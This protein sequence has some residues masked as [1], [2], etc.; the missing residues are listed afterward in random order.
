M[1]A[2]AGPRVRWWP[3]LAWPVD[4]PVPGAPR[5]PRGA[6]GP[7]RGPAA[8]GPLRGGVPLLTGPPL[9]SDGQLMV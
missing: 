7:R 5:R 1:T 9:D 8:R 4:V 6:R 3:S 2:R